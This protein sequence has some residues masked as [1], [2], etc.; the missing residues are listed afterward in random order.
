MNTTASHIAH[1]LTLHNHVG[2]PGLGC[3][4]STRVAAHYDG[5]CFRAPRRAIGFEAGPGDE[6]SLLAASLRRAGVAEPEVEG[7]IKRDVAQIMAELQTAGY[8]P[9]G[10]LG[11]LANHD[12]TLTFEPS[13]LPCAGP[14]LS[15][16]PVE[17]GESPAEKAAA[18]AVPVYPAFVRWAA[19]GAAAIF[20]FGLLAWFVVFVSNFTGNGNTMATIGGASI[21]AM[22]SREAEVETVQPQAPAPL[23]VIFQTPA[24]GT[25]A[26]EPV[27]APTEPT[28]DYCLIV[29]SLATEADALD[30]CR[31][32]S[33][34]SMPLTVVNI[35]GRYRISAAFGHDYAEVS[36]L[37]ATAPYAS[38][39]PSAW[40]CRR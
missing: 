34:E 22:P 38:L 20:G 35:D 12:G 1:L 24:D 3:F 33:T 31:Q 39:Y 28:G 13:A 40:I 25:Q 16:S 30:F 23:T 26:V 10:N 27:A 32:H 36:A 5:S 7:T 14:V 15:I 37:A 18:P 6:D 2:V 21:G 4:S 29:A 17:V 9:V 19:G 8:Y 11:R